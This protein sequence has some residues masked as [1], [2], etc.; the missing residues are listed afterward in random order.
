[1]PIDTIPKSHGP[2]A[3][4]SIPEAIKIAPVIKVRR[5]P[6]RCTRTLERSMPIIEL[7]NCTKNNEPEPESV[8][9]QRA[10][11]IGSIGPRKVIT[12]PVSRKST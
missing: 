8:S 1:M 3:R 4:R 11:R 10:E 12:I 6:H 9:D 7:K 5:Y 2:D